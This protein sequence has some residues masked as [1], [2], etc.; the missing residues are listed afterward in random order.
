NIRQ[1]AFKRTNG[2]QIFWPPDQVKR[3]QRLPDLFAVR[4]DHRDHVS[5][6]N[7]LAI[8]YVDLAQASADRRTDFRPAS[9][10]VRFPPPPLAHHPS[11]RNRGAGGGGINHS[12]RLRS[13]RLRR[14]KQGDYLRAPAGIAVTYQRKRG[15]AANQ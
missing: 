2:G 13:S 5:G 3:A 14:L 1:L 15:I 6:R 11:L 9:A 10:A 8:S 4:I 12:A 7:V